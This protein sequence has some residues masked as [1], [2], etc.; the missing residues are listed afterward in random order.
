VA[1]PNAAYVF[2]AR[3]SRESRL[4]PRLLAAGYRPLRTAEFVVY[5]KG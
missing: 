2:L 5:V 1:D 4:R 3:S